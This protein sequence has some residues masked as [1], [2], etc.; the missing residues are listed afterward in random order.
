MYDLDINDL[1]IPFRGLTHYTDRYA[2]AH[3]LY[4]THID[5]IK[6]LVSHS[7]GSVIVHN[8]IL[9][10]VQLK[11]RLYSTPYLAIPHARI[12]YFSHYGDPIAMFKFDRR[13]RRLC[14]GNPHT[15]TG[16]Q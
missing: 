9:E 16:Y 15:H 6:T 14:L 7:L 1:N 12:E 2:R 5:N 8:L 11:G 13:H 4:T 10:N 3:Q